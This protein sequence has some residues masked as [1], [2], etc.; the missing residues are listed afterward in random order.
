MNG[1][2]T[3]IY[4]KT[5]VEKVLGSSDQCYQVLWCLKLSIQL[6]FYLGERNSILGQK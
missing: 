3:H 5:T 2:N 1:C 6:K 4:P